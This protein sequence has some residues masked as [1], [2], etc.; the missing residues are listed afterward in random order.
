MWLLTTSALSVGSL[1]NL[2]VNLSLN[3][4]TDLM[5]GFHLAQVLLTESI[6]RC[7][8]WFD[9]LEDRSITHS[10]ISVFAQT[11]EKTDLAPCGAKV[12]QSC[13]C[14]QRRYRLSSS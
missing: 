10:V 7:D 8:H 4:R 1:A 13:S 11:L 3:L 6:A 12:R 9:R 5:D 2:F 14:A